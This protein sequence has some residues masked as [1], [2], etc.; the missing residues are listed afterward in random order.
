MKDK[1]TINKIKNIED[2]FLNL[3]AGALFAMAER[4]SSFEAFDDYTDKVDT[5]CVL[6]SNNGQSYTIHLGDKLVGAFMLLKDS[7]YHV[8][9]GLI[10]IRQFRNQGVFKQLIDLLIEEHTG[11]RIE[12]NNPYI[13]ESL[14]EDTRFYIDG[15]TNY[16]N[17]VN[18]VFKTHMTIDDIEIPSCDYCNGTGTEEENGDPI[19]CFKCEGTGEGC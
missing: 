19:G 7:G 8:I 10:V 1:V 11:V 12:S 6:D 14:K 17:K 9:I 2:P 13:C 15:N 18:I 3:A 16:L 4:E 5:Y